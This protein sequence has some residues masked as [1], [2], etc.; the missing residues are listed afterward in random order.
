M[1][2]DTKE[3]LRSHAGVIA[4]G[5]ILWVAL[6]LGNVRL[7]D[8]DTWQIINRYEPPVIKGGH[9]FLNPTVR[10]VRLKPELL[11]AD[12]F[13]FSIDVKLVE[14]S[15]LQVKLVQGT[16]S[17]ALTLKEGEGEYS[18]SNWYKIR[19]V[20]DGK[21]IHWYIGDDHKTDAD[22]PGD[23][24]FELELG[25]ETRIV[26]IDNVVIKDATGK[27]VLVDRFG[28]NVF[29]LVRT[30]LALIVCFLAAFLLYFI[31]CLVW[32]RISHE[33]T[34]RNIHS[35]FLV[36]WTAVLVYALVFG[37]HTS[38]TNAPFWIAFALIARLLML[39]KLEIIGEAPLGNATVS[40]MAS[41][42]GLAA[43]AYMAFDILGATW[44]FVVLD[45][46]F[47]ILLIGSFKIKQEL[48]RI[49]RCVF[50]C[51]P[52]AL[53]CV[54]LIRTEE[55]LN[56]LW[57]EQAGRG[58][59][60]VTT[61]GIVLFF[62]LSFVIV[63]RKRV[64]LSGILSTLL[65]ICILVS[66]EVGVRLSPITHRLTP[67]Q[68]GKT[69][70][71]DDA[72]FFVPDGF[73]A[74]ADGK[75]KGSAFIVREINFR[76]GIPERPKPEGL[77]RVVVMGGS[78]VWGDGVDNPQLTF[79]AWLEKDLRQRHPEKKIEVVNS[80]MQGYIVFQLFLMLRMYVIDYEPDLIVLYVNRNDSSSQFGPYTLRELWQ[81]RGNIPSVESVTEVVKTTP[82]SGEKARI[83][84]RKSKLYN[85]MVLAIV[86][87]REES[88]SGVTRKLKITKEVNP[89]SD[90]AA[91]LEEFIALCREKG[92][93]IMLADEYQFWHFP[94]GDQSRPIKIKKEMKR[95]AK[96]KNVP[97]LLVHDIL[98]E[99]Y[100]E[101]QMLFPTDIVHLNHE[102]HRLVAKM[103]ADFIDEQ[104]LME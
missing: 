19:A 90:Y 68:T 57:I 102:G 64:P 54:F 35:N 95:I 62:L 32:P 27:T 92:V 100:P 31:E 15:A 50:L 34:A 1:N 101:G 17:T 47:V 94:P 56:L 55:G 13:S 67:L 14:S 46:A 33:L 45:A 4:F 20:N 18:K 11:K 41:L 89:I 66:V 99:K 78:N 87:A 104:R 103:M 91:N 16:F 51:V 40:L 7:L 81:M 77:F 12:G 80:G 8:I 9:F 63:N 6:L 74:A 82:S 21:K 25:K 79:S 48:G 53:A 3:I 86:G 76:S 88:F 23:S 10:S 59:F 49:A 61:F 70:T 65:L 84:M 5:F 28:L 93:Q 52:V 58:L 85:A 83:W 36:G 75:G 69:F 26:R 24:P 71:D 60:V 42:G 97:Y 37:V 43:A 73:F 30:P 22:V 39:G 29:G 38:Y 2:E 96:E 72:L 98:T 44:L